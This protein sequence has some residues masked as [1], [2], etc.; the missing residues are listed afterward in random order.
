MRH[1]LKCQVTQM[2]NYICYK[3]AYNLGHTTSPHGHAS[4]LALKV[5]SFWLYI[6]PTSKA[7]SGCNS[8]HSDNFYSAV[9]LTHRATAI[10]AEW[11]VGGM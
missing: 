5:C 10:M 4:C 6:L 3:V 7:T 2:Y 9:P 8:V 1:Y 11:G